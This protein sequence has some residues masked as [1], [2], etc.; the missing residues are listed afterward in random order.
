[1][2]FLYSVKAKDK[3]VALSAEELLTMFNRNIA[4]NA[5]LLDYIGK[6]NIFGIIK[7]ARNESVHSCFVSELLSGDFFDGSSREST[8]T[9]FLD[10]LLP[11][12]INASP[13]W[14]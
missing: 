13:I 8:L 11:D 14:V 10:L 3:E 1:M 2:N 9:H 4:K 12:F 6:K 5:E 7:K